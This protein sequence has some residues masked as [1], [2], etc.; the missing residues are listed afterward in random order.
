MV[1]WELFGKKASQ[2]SLKHGQS[3]FPV[4]IQM[5]IQGGRPLLIRALEGLL[6]ITSASDRS[7]PNLQVCLCNY[8]ECLRQTGKSPKDVRDTL[9]K[10]MRPYGLR[11]SL[12]FD[13]RKQ[14]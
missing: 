4:P 11:V 10:I 6:N 9:E 13:D 7:H 2:Y 5:R 3:C 14:R 12:K 8:A 1:F